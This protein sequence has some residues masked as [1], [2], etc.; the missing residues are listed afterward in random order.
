MTLFSGVFFPVQSLP[1]VPRA[2]AYVSP[3]WHGVELCR[4]ATLGAGQSGA[5]AGHAAYLGLWG[6]GGYLLARA[7][8]ARR[9]AD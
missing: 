4:A 5:L 7:R 6:I 1:A 8:F 3:L 2:L 9:L